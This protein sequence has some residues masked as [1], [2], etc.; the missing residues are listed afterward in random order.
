MSCNILDKNERATFNEGLNK[1]QVIS[2][3]VC[4]ALLK[5]RQVILQYFE[6]S[7]NIAFLMRTFE[8]SIK[9]TVSSI[10]VAAACLLMDNFL[11]GILLK[12]QLDPVK[13][14]ENQVKQISETIK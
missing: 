8:Y 1:G 10:G 5:A 4:Y 13:N 2:Q 12:R 11:S 9:E 3:N 7:Q 6:R 14:V